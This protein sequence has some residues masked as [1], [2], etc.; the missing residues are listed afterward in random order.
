[1][2][3]M[4]QEKK[5]GKALIGIDLGGTSMKIGILDT[6]YRI[7]ARK[8]VPTDAKRPYG[9]V[10]ADMGRAAV[11]LLKENG[12][13][14][15]DCYG[16]GVG[17]PGTVDSQNGVVLYS[18]NIRWDNVPLAAEL[19][20][21][22]PVPVRVSNDA[23]CAALGETV[24]GAA[25]G[26]KNAVFLTLGTGV[27]GGIVI[28]GKIFE[29]GHPGGA[30]LGHIK[31]GAEG[32]Q[33]TCGRL[34]CL[35]AYASA[36]ALIKDA[37]EM[38]AGHPE[39]AL[40]EL[41][42]HDLNKMDAKMPFDAAWAGDEC[43]LLLVRNYIRYLGEGIT[44]IVNIFRPDIIVIG[45]GVCAQGERLT[46]PLNQFLQENCF[47][48]SVSYIPKVVAAQNGNDAGII[49]AASLIGTAGPGTMAYPGKAQAKRQLLF[50]EPVC[51]DNIW[52]GNRLKKEFHYLSA[53][54]R[55]GECW[56]ISAHPNGDGMVK[57]GELAGQKLSEVW[58]RHP[59]LFGIGQADGSVFPLLV[60]II[61]AKE[62]LSIQVHPG[63]A[64]AK[65]YENGAKGK[66]EC[67]YILDCASQ[68]SIV[69]G[70]NAK[71]KEELEDMVLGG[72]WEGLLRE[73]PIRKGDFIQIDPGTVHA[74]KG[75]CLILETQ[76]NSDVTYRLYD[77]GR[78]SDG[79]P[80][81]LHI[82]KS[83]DVITVPA[84]GAGECMMHPANLPKNSLN[85]LYHNE[86]YQIFKLDVDGEAE[87]FPGQQ[88]PYL[89]MSVLDGNG[90]A[91]GYPLKK[92]DHFLVPYGYGKLKLSGEMEII[93]SAPGI[94]P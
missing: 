68:A 9:Q 60:K 78:L 28:D 42:G 48:A 81:Q 77:Y 86:Y 6:N 70:H 66:T 17:S 85:E 51:S 44:D 23:D 20:R 10:I 55:A 4:N 47:G 7:L 39:S 5:P 57:N 26:Y 61:D 1:M 50:M 41:C 21:Y 80:R 93:A 12:Y 94:M 84:K 15:E 89:L 33:C 34:D 16:A 79:K 64:Y 8:S 91:D 87:I 72:K 27:G 43:G 52:G 59:E 58:E 18:N 65:T 92:G 56:G 19:Q 71:T 31:N 29:G 54:E 25:K 45:G 22:L 90:W 63:D 2:S 38:A 53:K 32:R 30:E 11:A 3:E 67:W 62:D 14:F 75:G 76:Q 88:F 24:K 82:E 73:V 40:W 46:Q 49:G 69:F 13:R 37:A 74:I 35:E 83:L 36:T